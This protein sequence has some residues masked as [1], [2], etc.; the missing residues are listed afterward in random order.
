MPNHHVKC[1]MDHAHPF[2][3]DR[4]GIL[5]AILQIVIIKITIRTRNPQSGYKILKYV[6]QL[7]FVSLFSTL[8]G[9]N[10]CKLMMNYT[11]EN[12][13][14]TFQQCCGSDCGL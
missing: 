9:D 4:Q 11:L 6:F 8:L 2:I 1:W 3:W 14:L 5:L 10:L 13:K 7:I 12:I